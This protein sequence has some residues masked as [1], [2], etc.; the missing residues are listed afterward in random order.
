MLEGHSHC[1]VN[2]S[3]VRRQSS[4]YA[5][6][7]LF[8]L[9]IMHSNLLEVTCRRSVRRKSSNYME[10]SNYSVFELE[11]VYLYRTW[12]DF[13]KSRKENFVCMIR[14]PKSKKLHKLVS[15]AKHK[16]R[17]VKGE[18]KAK[19]KISPVVVFGVL[20]RMVL[21]RES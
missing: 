18:V 2:C 3:S 16:S 12:N 20:S 21:V 4:N 6:G 1:T 9:R 14:K 11:G 17:E 15:R 19:I 13:G 7:A 5:A 10:C 8:V